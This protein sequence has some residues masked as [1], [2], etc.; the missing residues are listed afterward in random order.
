MKTIIKKYWTLG[1]MLLA[2][3]ACNQDPELT[4]LGDINFPAE[5]E[6]SSSDLVITES[7]LND[8]IL[9]VNWSEVDYLIGAPVDYTVQFSTPN[10]TVGANAWGNAKSV[11]AGTD[12]LTKTF[13]AKD[14]NKY[15]LAFGLEANVQGKIVVRVKSYVDRDA[16]STPKTINFTP[17]E[18]VVVDPEPDPE[19]EPTMPSLWVPGDFQG[20]DPA[21]APHIADRGTGIYEGYINIPDGGTNEFKLTPQAAW[22]PTAYG[23]T[24]AGKLIEANDAGNNIVAPGPG[25]YM[26]TANLDA[27]S[28]SITKTEWGIIGDATLGGWDTDTPMVYDAVTRVWKV[29]T[30]MSAAGSFKFRANNAWIIDFGVDANGKMMYADHPVLGYT[31]DLNNLTVP[32]AGNYTITLDLHDPENYSYVLHLN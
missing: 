11:K 29:T 28:Y 23:S 4:V 14:L 18:K 9:I 13:K 21:T 17:Y 8:D 3:T 12:V 15:A 31:A 2:L 24:E 5:I 22:T 10:D 27:M 20:W 16:F 32:E 26:L 19:P 6:I 25:Y 1:L 7:N 30:D